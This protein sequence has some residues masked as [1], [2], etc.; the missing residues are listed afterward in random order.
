MLDEYDSIILTAFAFATL[1]RA[2]DQAGDSL[3]AFSAAMEKAR[4]EFEA[5][6]SPDDYAAYRALLTGHPEWGW[7]DAAAAIGR[8]KKEAHAR[9]TDLMKLFCVVALVVVALLIAAPAGAQSLTRPHLTLAIAAGVDVATTL[10]FPPGGLEVNPS[11]AWLQTKSEVLMVSVGAAEETA[12][13]L[14]VEHFLKPKHPTATRRLVYVL[15]AVHFT[16]AGSNLYQA[17]LQRQDRAR[18]HQR[19]IIGLP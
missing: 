14:L 5:R 17:N 9:K 13:V 1:S 8:T 2:M 11:V 10:S 4:I 15:S 3:R 19:A 6:L 12:A 16:A 7:V 18:A